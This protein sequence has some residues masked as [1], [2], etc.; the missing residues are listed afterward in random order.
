MRVVVD[1]DGWELLETASEPASST[2][3]ISSD[4]AGKAPGS[5]VFRK[6]VEDEATMPTDPAPAP[7][8]ELDPSLD[9]RLP[10]PARLPPDLTGDK[11]R[12]A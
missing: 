5:G 7:A 3:P 10:G 4:T 11:T 1:V 9:V 2:P 6:V 8:G 12:V